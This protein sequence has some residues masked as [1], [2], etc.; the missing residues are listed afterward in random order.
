MAE[1]F[2]HTAAF[3][4]FGTV[5][6]NVNWS[7][8]ARN[9]STKTVVVTL[10]QDEFVYK[11]D[12]S[13]KKQPFYQSNDFYASASK[14][15]GL[16]ELFENLQWAKDH[17]EGLLHVIVAIAK[18]AAVRPRS[19]YECFPTDIRLKI[20]AFDKNTKVFSLGPAV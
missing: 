6:R 5:P 10:W 15:N 18:D 4:Y 16:N 12:E 17:C 2:T 13:G 9:E 19:I 8:S 3:K 1:K 20:L 14:S 7:W 11:A